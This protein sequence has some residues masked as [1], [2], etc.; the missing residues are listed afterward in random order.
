MNCCRIEAARVEIYVA[1]IL[2]LIL[3]SYLI[4]N[5]C[6]ASCVNQPI[7]TPTSAP[8]QCFARRLTLPLR[9]FS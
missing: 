1:N 7:L 5:T 3:L 6:S 2:S 9:I 4:F 8:S